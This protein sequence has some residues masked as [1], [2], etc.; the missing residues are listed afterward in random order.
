[1]SN[2]QLKAPGEAA[3]E[4]VLSILSK[5]I[6]DN[7]VTKDQVIKFIQN[8]IDEDPDRFKGDDAVI[9]ANFLTEGGFGN[10]RY[11]NGHFQYFN[12]S[13]GEW[14]DTSITPN[15][16]Y[17]MNMIPQQMR[18]IIG[19]YDHSVGHYK[20]RWQEPDD[21]IINGQVASVVEKVIIRRKLGSVP[22]DENDGSFVTEI[23]RN[24]FG[25]FIDTWFTDSELT[26]NIGDKYFYKAFPFSTLGFTNY[27]TDNETDGILCKDYVLYG[28]H[29]VHINGG[30]SDPDSMFEYIE[31]NKRFRPA[32]M[33]YTADSFSYGDW[34]DEWFIKN[35]RPVMLNNDGTV[36]YELNKNDYSK[37]L[38]GTPSDVSN[39]DFAGNAMIEFPKVY[40][41]IVNNEDDT[42]DIYV[43]DK[44]VDESFHCWSH[45]DESGNEIDFCYMPIYNGTVINNKLRSLSGKVPLTKATRMQE[46]SYAIAN[47]AG[48]VIYSTETFSDWILVNILLILIGRSTDSKKVFGTGNNK[49]Y[50]S[51]SNTGV[52][53]T[54]TMDQ[55]G[56]FWGDQS[57][58]FGVKVFGMEHFWGN[59]WRGIHGWINNKGTQKVKLTYSMNDGTTV[60]GYNYDGTG[61][62][63]I[64]NSTPSGG[65]NGYGFLSKML[66]TE[67]GLIPVVANGAASTFYTVG[68]WYNNGQVDYALVGGG[69]GSGSGVGALYADLSHAASS[70]KIVWSVGASLSCKPLSP[71]V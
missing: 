58:K 52:K 28:V 12:T 45:L 60:N 67:E 20:L 42:A 35:L 7:T 51:A 14:I 11:Y 23:K 62:I 33:N 32:A 9:D 64:P 48:N 15:N 56:L 22:T 57:N 4:E 8:I 27:S 46:I 26:P 10:L 41:K 68:F 65:N 66:F 43:S 17:I 36:A 55:K 50:D 70:A 54:G 2:N 6:K 1:M 19:V 16:V 13:T 71:A 29:A 44:Q 38:D 59:I 24:S 37:R 63:T 34:K 47:N 39:A 3:I 31:D 53:N 69:S 5:A 49:S 21:T 61:Y 18:N 40:W 30:E 25:S